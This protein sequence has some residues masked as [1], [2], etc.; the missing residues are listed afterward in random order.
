MPETKLDDPETGGRGVG[1]AG[2]KKPNDNMNN[3]IKK[4]R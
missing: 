1:N 2:S 4:S 3:F